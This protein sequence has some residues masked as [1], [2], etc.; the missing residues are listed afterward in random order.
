LP[1]KKKAV[2]PDMAIMVTRFAAEIGTALLADMAVG[3]TFAT[4]R[5]QN[6][7]GHIRVG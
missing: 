1:F 4:N 5:V 6:R 3:Q 2:F 7:L